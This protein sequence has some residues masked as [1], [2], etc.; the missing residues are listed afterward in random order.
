M[1]WWEMSDKAASSVEGAF[2]VSAGLGQM[3]S[4][5]AQAAVY[6]E[7]SKI[8]WQNAQFNAKL[9]DIRSK[10]T[11]EA[12]HEQQA[13]YMEQAGQALGGNKVDYA[14][15]GVKVNTGAAYQVTGESFV[16]AQ[17]NALMMENNLRNEQLGLQT[18]KM[19][20]LSQGK[21][22]ATALKYTAQQTLLGGFAKGFSNIGQGAM[23]IIK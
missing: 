7:Q 20:T 2:Q 17:N 18:A 23:K 21:L 11:A 12:T 22:E 9:I 10:Q 15:Q 3:A 1:S 4:G 19:N 14:S 13:A 5:F 16:N 6:R 8:A